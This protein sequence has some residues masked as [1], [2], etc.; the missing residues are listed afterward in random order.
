MKNLKSVSWLKEHLND[1]NLILLDASQDSNIS[2]EISNLAGKHIP[3]SQIFDI[4]NTF[5]DTT[6]Q[7]PNTVPS[8]T[9]FQREVQKLGISFDSV[10]VVYDNIGIYTSPRAW[11]LFRYFG[12]SQVFV[13]DGGLPQWALEGNK[14]TSQLRILSLGNFKSIVQPILIKSIKDIQQNIDSC[15]FEVVDA[16]SE[17]RFNSR[18]PEPRKGLRSGN[19]PNSSNIPYSEVLNLGKMKNTEQLNTIFKNVI[20]K[21]RPITCS[22]GSGITACILLLAYQEITDK[23]ASIYDGSWTEWGTLKDK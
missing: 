3:N 23:T 8:S 19:I 22:C 2:G 4:K 20:V 21:N 13:L 11:W 12:H 5:S 16:R 10:I 9:Q 15:D 18:V 14:I 1:N 6:S 7:F 17:A